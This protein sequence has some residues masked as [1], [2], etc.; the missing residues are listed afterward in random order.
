MNKYDK[1]LK[2]LRKQS[3]VYESLKLNA[4]NLSTKLGAIE[5]KKH[6]DAQIRAVLLATFDIED[7]IKTIEQVLE[8]VQ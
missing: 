8:S 5:L 3:R 6:V 2:S 7:G 1:T 4:G